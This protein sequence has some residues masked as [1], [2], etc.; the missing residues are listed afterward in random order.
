[1]SFWMMRTTGWTCQR[2]LGPCFAGRRLPTLRFCAPETL[3]FLQTEWVA[4]DHSI[5]PRK[6]GCELKRTSMPT[7]AACLA[8]PTV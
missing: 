6:P 2:G 3:E 4:G 1:M 7:W 8:W 5:G